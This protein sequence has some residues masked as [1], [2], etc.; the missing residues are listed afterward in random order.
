M[1]IKNI[2]ITGALGLGLVGGAQL[3]EDHVQDQAIAE[4]HAEE[5]RMEDGWREQRIESQC[6]DY[7][8]NNVRRVGSLEEQVEIDMAT[9]RAC[10]KVMKTVGDFPFAEL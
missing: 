2:A 10:E 3:C 6:T 7:V 5:K 1:S 9:Q 4:A 8:R